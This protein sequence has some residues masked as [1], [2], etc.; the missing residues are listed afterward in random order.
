MAEVSIE[1]NDVA[2]IGVVKDTPPYQL[3][4]EAW[5]LAENMRF[6]DS[7]IARIGGTNPIFGTPPIAP[8]FAQFVSTAAQPWWLYTS[9]T[10]AYV[11]DGSAHTNITRQTAS[12]D[13]N[14]NATSAADW[15][16]TLLGGVPILNNGVDVPQYW[17]AYSAAQKLQ[18]LPNWTAGMTAK[19]VRSFGP[20]LLALNITLAGVVKGNDVR[21]SAPA[22]PGT[23]P[24]SWDI[25]DPTRNAGTVSLPDIDSG[26]ILDGLPLQG[27]FYVYKENSCWRFR[28]IGGRFI[29]DEDAFLETIGLLAPRCVA[30][31]GDGQRHVFMSNDDMYVHDGNSAKPLLS[32][33]MKR[34]IFNQID[35]ANYGQSFLFVNALR[36][37]AWFCYPSQGN[38][39]PNR[40][41][42]VNYNNGAATETDIDFQ[43]AAIGTL[44]TSDTDTWASAV[45]VWETDTSPWSVSNRRRIALLKPTATKFLQMDSGSVR[46]GTA[47]TG[48]LQRTALGVIGRK[49]NGEWIEDFETRKLVTRVWPKLSGGPVSIRLGGQD[50]PNG[51]ITWSPSKVFDPSSQKYCD[52]IAEGAAISIEISAATDWQ[53]DGYKLDM[54][55][56]GKF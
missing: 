2:S 31:T 1:I 44:Q 56:L 19:V 50:I 32:N 9:L 42:I 12:V 51:P 33:R 17:A 53:L 8:Y 28:N 46:D 10:K 13:V 20:Y 14:Y 45:G 27:K 4:P 55:T 23:V 3:P 24:P 11:Y 21:W 26:I 15:N 39:V 52:L 35:T 29:F 30:I 25:A 38:L 48:L 5:S 37:E 16:G 34:Y 49:R 43:F 6:N 7:S 40:G 36:A 41:I 47:F 22:D 54:V 18:N